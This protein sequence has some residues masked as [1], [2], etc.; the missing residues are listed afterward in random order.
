MTQDKSSDQ[1]DETLTCV[2][3][4]NCLPFG[5][6]DQGRRQPIVP[7][8]ETAS[9]CQQEPSAPAPVP[10]STHPLSRPLLLPLQK[11]NGKEGNGFHSEPE[12]DRQE[13]ADLICHTPGNLAAFIGIIE[14]LA[15]PTRPCRSSSGFLVASS[16]SDTILQIATDARVRTLLFSSTQEAEPN[17]HVGPT[18]DELRNFESSVVESLKSARHMFALGPGPLKEH[19][20]HHPQDKPDRKHGLF[21]GTP[22]NAILHAAS[23][24]SRRD[25]RQALA[26]PQP[27][28]GISHVRKG[29]TWPG[30][31][32]PPGALPTGS[33]VMAQAPP[34][35][36]IAWIHRAPALVAVGTFFR[37]PASGP[38]SLTA[39]PEAPPLVIVPG[40]TD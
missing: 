8:V 7:P 13:R 3:R 39:S 22:P 17:V 32:G 29:W 26:T 5:A 34:D 27:P 23:Y 2:A 4:R 33:L 10:L 40:R 20:P 12:C 9:K 6:E 1:A 38:A 21:G 35:Y 18:H 19:H 37:E 31:L 36:P 15:F 24:F 30:N 16:S 25:L 14:R 11:T 28:E